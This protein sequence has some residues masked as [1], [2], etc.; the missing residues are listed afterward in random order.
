M[1]KEIEGRI[2]DNAFF[3]L[4]LIIADAGSVHFDLGA[5]FHTGVFGSHEDD[6]VGIVH[7]RR[8][9]YK[10]IFKSIKNIL[11]EKDINSLIVLT[12]IPIITKLKKILSN[13]K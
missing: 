13:R 6:V 8:F 12:I 9:F 7:Y 4:D 2:G 3:R 11:S 1:E 5:G 10:N